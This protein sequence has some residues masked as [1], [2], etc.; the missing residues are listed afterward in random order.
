MNPS[1]CRAIDTEVRIFRSSSTS[2]ITWLIRA[3][4]LAAYAPLGSETSW[5]ARFDRATFSGL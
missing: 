1:D 2:A 3:V 5:S 4:R